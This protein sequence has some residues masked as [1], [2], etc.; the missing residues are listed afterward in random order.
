MLYKY[1]YEQIIHIYINLLTHTHTTN[2]SVSVYPYKC[3]YT[4]DLSRNI[5]FI[6]IKSK[7]NKNRPAESTFVHFKWLSLG[8]KILLTEFLPLFKTICEVFFQDCHLLFIPVYSISA[9]IWPFCEKSELAGSQT[10]NFWESNTLG[11]QCIILPKFL[12]EAWS[13]WTWQSH[14]SWFHSVASH[15]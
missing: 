13:L 7:T 11:E 15:H 14:S 9:A 8:P 4:Q 12:D 1:Q 3:S 10:L 5:C 2:I 6:N